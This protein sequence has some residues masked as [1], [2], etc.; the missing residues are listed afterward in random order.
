M[1]RRRF[2][3]ALPAAAALHAQ[4][5]A[6]PRFSGRTMDGQKFDTDSLKGK[7]A[8]LQFWTTWCGYC[9]KD[10]PALEQLHKEYVPAQLSMLAINVNEPREKVEEYLKQSPRSPKIVLSSDTDL[11]KLV[12]PRGFPVYILLDKNG[13]MVHRQDGSGGILALRQMLLEVGLQKGS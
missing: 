6:V 1:D 13:M 12:A 3:F 2:L 4:P 10:Q 5:Q 7:P 9:R 11:V 8:L